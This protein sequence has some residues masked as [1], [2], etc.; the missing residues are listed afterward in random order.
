M[1]DFLIVDSVF[2]TYNDKTI[3][4]DIFMKCETGD[5]IGVFGRN[6]SGKSTLFKIIYGILDAENKYVRLNDKVL[7]KP[8]LE[9]NGI[10]YLPQ[11]NF[12]PWHFTVKKAVNL[13][14]DSQVFSQFYEDEILKKLLNSRMNELSGGELKYF[15]TKLLLFDESKFCLLDEPYSGLSPIMIDV[16]NQL[17]V[18]QSSH[19][20]ILIAE[21]NYR[22]LLDVA[23]KIYFLKDGSGRFLQNKYELIRYGYLSEGMI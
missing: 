1:N 20:G 9:K 17:I 11:D 6:G 7:Q 12:I 14:L 18:S 23:N 8:Y 22:Y 21:H 15:Q 19:K 2:K 13:S 5:I 3:L 16:V 10:S 4:S